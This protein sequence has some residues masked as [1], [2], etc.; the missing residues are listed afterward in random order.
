MMATAHSD[1]TP[2]RERAEATRT[3]I[4]RAARELVVEHGYD[5]VSTGQVLERAGVSRG[6]LY[7]HFS[8]MD[9]LM[10]AVLEAVETDFTVR[11]TAALADA[12]VSDPFE[13]LATGTQWYLDECIRSKELQR[14]GLYEGRAALG[15]RAWREI[16]APYGLTVLAAGLESGI[17]GG[18]IEPADPLALA[19]LILAAMHEAV[20]MILAAPDPVSERERVGQAVAVLVEGLRRRG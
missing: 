6:G 12:E 17:E 2:A 19:H 14:V 5:G 20:T 8:G 10:G 9:E 3:K 7:H 15:W 16:V 11:L 18:Q 13:T 1:I 4:V